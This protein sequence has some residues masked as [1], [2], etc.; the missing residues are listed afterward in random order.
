MGTGS[1]GLVLDTDMMRH[2][3]EKTADTMDDL[4]HHTTREMDEEEENYQSTPMLNTSP[5]H[6]MMM[7]GGATPGNY[8]EWVQD[9]MMTPQQNQYMVGA[10]K[11]AQSPSYINTPYHNPA[12]SVYNPQTPIYSAMSPAASSPAYSSNVQSSGQRHSPAYNAMGSAPYAAG[13]GYTPGSQMHSSPQ[14]S[15]STSN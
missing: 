15:P 14:Y 9:A 3:I 13:H 11:G 12:S 1:F 10:S 5:D 6:Q 7:T 2:A 8:S 4:H